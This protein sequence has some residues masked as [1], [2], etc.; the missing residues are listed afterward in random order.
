MNVKGHSFTAEA[1]VECVPKEWSEWSACDCNTGR[2]NRTRE[3]VIPPG[4]S[5]VVCQLHRLEFDDNCSAECSGIG[6]AIIIALHNHSYFI[7]HACTSNNY[8]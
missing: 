8:I 5:D 3:A 2:R 7:M 1:T 6:N 4:I